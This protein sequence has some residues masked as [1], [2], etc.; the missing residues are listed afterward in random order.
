[1]ESGRCWCV[2]RRLRPDSGRGGWDPVPFSVFRAR[3]SFGEGGLH[4]ASVTEAQAQG[5]AVVMLVGSGRHGR[6]ALPPFCPLWTGS[7]MH[8]APCRTSSWVRRPPPGCC[9][10]RPQ[11]ASRW[12]C[13]STRWGKP[14][15]RPW[16]MAAPT[17]LLT[18]SLQPRPSHGGA[19]AP[20]GRPS[21]V[22][23]AVARPG[24]LPRLGWGLCPL[25]TGRVVPRDPPGA[26]HWRPSPCDNRSSKGENNPM[27]VLVINLARARDR[28]P[29]A[30]LKGRPAPGTTFVRPWHPC[31][32][33]R[34]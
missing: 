18:V 33:D 3:P 8:G 5:A 15:R 11:H 21:H 14:G 27:D 4:G 10:T 32:R 6:I 25:V 23:R 19:S 29:A 13:C 12:T 22:A 28:C 20:D 9:N 30:P 17:G 24:R 2:S 1:M 16:T 31:G 7:R 26:V 34:R